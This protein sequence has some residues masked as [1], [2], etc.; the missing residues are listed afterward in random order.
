CL[1][2]DAA[3]AVFEVLPG[4]VII[5]GPD[6][7]QEGPLFAGGGTVRVDVYGQGF[8]GMSGIQ[9]GLRRTDSQGHVEPLLVSTHD[10]D[11]EFGGLAVFPNPELTASPFNVFD[12]SRLCAGF[13]ALD[14][15]FDLPQKTLLLSI[16]CDYPFDAAIG[17]QQVTFDPDLTIVAIG[18]ESAP[19]EVTPGGMSVLGRLQVEGPADRGDSCR[20]QGGGSFVVNILA[21]RIRNLGGVQAAL[22]FLDSAGAPSPEFAISTTDGDPAFCGLHVSHNSTLFPSISP[23]CDPANG[24]VGFVT[25]G[26]NAD[27]PEPSRLLSIVYNYTGN[28]ATG[29]YSIVFNGDH[30]FAACQSGH[31]PFQPIE[32]SIVIRNAWPIPGDANS[33]CTVNILDLIYVRNALNQNPESGNNCM[34]DINRDGR[35]NI[36]DLILIRGR[37]GARCQ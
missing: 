20:L 37:L 3:A 32:G 28:A 18:P 24:T 4:R 13:I 29:T 11:P 35:I 22:V 16:V 19:C 2:S 26:E 9:V 12:D 34:A 1:D 15:D 27:L 30:T 25:Q 5:E 23:I 6:Q 36:L 14:G 33:D 17:S 21:E 31:I 7:R 10:G 8:T